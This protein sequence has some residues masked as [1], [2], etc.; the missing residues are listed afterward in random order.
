[1]NESSTLVYYN[2]S[3]YQSMLDKWSALTSLKVCLS[4]TIMI[5]S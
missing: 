3:L 4:L 2:H 1:M 5:A